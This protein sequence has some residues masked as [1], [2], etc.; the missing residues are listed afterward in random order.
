MMDKII[1]MPYRQYKTSYADCKTVYGSYDSNS[2]TVEVVIPEGRMK[3]S[4][5]RGRTF[6]TIWLRV[7][8]DKDHLFEQ[9]FKA[10]DADHAIKQAK[11]YYNFV[12]MD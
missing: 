4:G 12:L 5:V 10:V 3:P 11:K 8:K 6:R 2:K 9:G 7:G 1:R